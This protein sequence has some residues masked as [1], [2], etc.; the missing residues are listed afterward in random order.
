M[1]FAALLA[2]LL[3]VVVSTNVLYAQQADLMREMGLQCEAVAAGEATV[4][5]FQTRTKTNIVVPV[6]GILKKPK[7][8][9]P[10]PAV[11]V[12]HGGTGDQPRRNCFASISLF[13]FR[14]RRA[15]TR[16]RANPPPVSRVS[17]C[18]CRG[19]FSAGLKQNERRNG[20]D[21]QPSEK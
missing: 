9:G 8:A 2:F 16:G 4:V 13:E 21:L 18:A 5:A 17:R 20:G 7:G 3:L 1:P 15:N 11:V 6:E 14:T 19:Y 12:M 10:F